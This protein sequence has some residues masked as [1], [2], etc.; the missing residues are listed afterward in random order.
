MP[1]IFPSSSSIDG[2]KWSNYG[3]ILHHWT[4]QDASHNVL[5]QTFADIAV[6]ATMED[7]ESAGED[8]T[9]N[10]IKKSKHWIVVPHALARATKYCSLKWLMDF[11]VSHSILIKRGGRDATLD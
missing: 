4:M 2:V 8:E 1:Y 10:K 3:H 5:Q 11:D 9:G 7:G 6:A